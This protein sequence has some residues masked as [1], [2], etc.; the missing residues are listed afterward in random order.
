MSLII[1]LIFSQFRSSSESCECDIAG[2]D[3]GCFTDS[4]YYLGTCFDSEVILDDL[5]G[6]VSTDGNLILNNAKGQE[7]NLK[8]V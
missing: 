6:T 1:C 7:L 4:H 2:D 5:T 3:C 8:K